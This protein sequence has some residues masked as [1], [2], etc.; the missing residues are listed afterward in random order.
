MRNGV[1][2]LAPLGKIPT[3]TPFSASSFWGELI[4]QTDGIINGT[5]NFPYNLP[6][7][8]ISPSSPSMQTQAILDAPYTRPNLYQLADGYGTRLGQAYQSL[9]RWSNSEPYSSTQAN[10]QNTQQWTG[11]S[12]NVTNLIWFTGTKLRDSNLGVRSILGT[13]ETSQPEINYTAELT[14][15]GV[16][17]GVMARAYGLPAPGQASITINAYSPTTEALIYQTN[18]FGDPN[19]LGGAVFVNDITFKTGGFNVRPF[20]VFSFDNTLGNLPSFYARNYNTDGNCVTST[21][22]NYNSNWAY[23]FESGDRRDNEPPIGFDG[24]TT[25]SSYA[26]G[27]A[28]Y[29]WYGGLI[30]GMLLPERFQQMNTR[31]AENAFGR[32]IGGW[33]W[34]TDIVA[35][36]TLS[37]FGIAQMM[38]GENG[39]YGTVDRDIPAGNPNLESPSSPAPVIGP[40]GSNNSLQNLL[41]L[42]R[43]D[44]V[45]AMTERCGASIAICAQDDTSR[46]A[47]KETN[48]RFYEATL[49]MGLPRVYSDT[50]LLGYNFDFNSLNPASSYVAWRR[51]GNSLTS[52]QVTTQE[53]HYASNAG[54]LIETRFPYLS[55]GQKNDILTTTAIS[56]VGQFLE[57]GSAYGA[58]SRINLFK[59]SDGYGAFLN[60]VVVTMDATLG[61]FNAAD[62][63]SNDIGQRGGTW[64]LTKIGS[65]LLTLA[66]NNTFTGPITINGGSLNITGSVSQSSGIVATAG[67]LAGTGNLPSTTINS[68]ATHAPGNS[69]GTQTVNGFYE[70]NGGTLGI[71][72]QGPQNDRINVTG[73]VNIFSGDANLISYGGGTPWPSFNYTIVS[74]STSTPFAEAD[75]LIV[76]ASQM[77]SALLNLGTQIVQEADGNPLTFDLQWRPNNGSGA[78]ASAMQALGQGGTNQLATA[79]AFDRVFQSLSTNAANNANNTG[80]LIGSTGFTTGQ[81]AAAGIS[82]D[83]LSVT[84]QLLALSSNSQLAGA[85]NSLSAEPYAAFQSVGLDTLKRQRELL[86]SQA[87]NCINTGWVINAPS[88]K[89]DKAPKKPLCVFVQASNA[90]S[91]INGSNG[92][93]S[94]DSGIFSSFYGVEYQPSK[95]WTVG[96]SYG[97]GTSYLNSMALA[98]DLVTSVVNSGSLY[99]VYKPSNRWNIRGLFGYANFNSSGSR[100]I[101]SIGNGSPIQGSP[102]ANGYTV[103]IN[104]DY[105]INLSTASAKTQAYLKPIIGLAWGGYQQNAFSESAGGALNLDIKGHTANSLI[106]TIGFE[107]ATSTIALNKSKTTAITPRLAVAY[108]VDALANDTGVKTLTSTFHSAPAAGTF[109]AQGENR[110]VNAIIIDGGIDIKVAQNTSL[111]ASAGYEI[112][113]H[114]SQ[115]TYGCGMKV[116]F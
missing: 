54:Y 9:A 41:Q 113:S 94:Y 1:Y 18:A 20:E 14:S 77:P 51:L 82:A 86:M 100:N 7:S 33:H 42:A 101:V 71:E 80:S 108:Q 15:L 104:A 17:T 114:G 24:Q 13:G 4:K 67:V 58:Y 25:S 97:Y 39:Y 83:F 61:G 52:D 12:K 2:G 34:P 55:L 110:G 23:F 93:S 56:E 73:N 88:G 99:A 48:R 38:A 46:F 74:A 36:R 31:G 65:G 96:A 109:V 30:M 29:G 63:W 87:G 89:K 53:R 103:A 75:S 26:S 40:A 66:G 64:G 69:I 95:N 107:L 11:I 115:F 10:G 37:Y 32:I 3:P 91:S 98:N 8:S 79:G 43:T 21:C 72:F 16:A 102:T 76:N 68:G 50:D 70:L 57:N 81:A 19:A 59:A 116:K 60:N 6:L 44:M 106:G 35:S 78:T 22:Q 27:H 105:L 5:T 84:A 49:T 111:Y 62:T 85:I 112:F 28:I 90:T 45:Q 47:D 92:L